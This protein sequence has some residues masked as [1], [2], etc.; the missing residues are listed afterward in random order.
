[1]S[2]KDPIEAEPMRTKK[3]V[4]VINGLEMWTK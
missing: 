1:M 3:T 2:D 4:R